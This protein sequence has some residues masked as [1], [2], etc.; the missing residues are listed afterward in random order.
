M[1]S[2]IQKLGVVMFVLLALVSLSACSSTQ[3][4]GEQVDDGIIV[5]K[6]KSKLAADGDINPFNIDVDSNDGVVTLQGTVAKSEARSKAEEHAR[7]TEGV[8]RVINL[9]KVEPS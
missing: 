4:T 8:V 3:T 6:V 2:K 5:T 9:I 7:G 1:S